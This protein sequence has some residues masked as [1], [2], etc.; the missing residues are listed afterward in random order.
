LAGP[1]AEA[2]AEFPISA[3]NKDIVTLL[4]ILVII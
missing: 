1:V 2:R 3:F 4:Y